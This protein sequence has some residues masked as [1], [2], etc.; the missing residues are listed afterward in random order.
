MTARLHLKTS[1]LPPPQLALVAAYQLSEVE[2]WPEHTYANDTQI[3]LTNASATL[4]NAVKGEGVIECM[5]GVLAKVNLPAV[6][7]AI[8]AKVMLE[9]GGRWSGFGSPLISK[10]GCL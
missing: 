6:D 7:P 2:V 9:F 3:L 10:A 4:V 1:F 5:V 8:Y